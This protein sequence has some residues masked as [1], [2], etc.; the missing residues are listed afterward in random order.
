MET[1]LQDDDLL[2]AGIDEAGYGPLLGPLC[3]AMTVVRVRDVPECPPDLWDLLDRAVCREGKDA[4]TSR[5]AVNDSKRLKLANSSEKR[6]P[7]MH[8][9]RG[10]LAFGAQCGGRE[11][12]STDE[13][14]LEMLGVG[15][16]CPWYTGAPRALPLSTTAEHLGLLRSG[17]T[18]ALRQAGVEMLDMHCRAV[19][20]QGFN[21]RLADVGVKSRVCSG[22]VGELMRRVWGSQACARCTDRP[23]R[24]V[25]DR[26]GGRRSYV[27]L[28]ETE[29][30]DGRVQV[31]R[32]RP[33]GS[34]YDV[35][36]AD[37]R[38]LRV[39]FLTEA[40]RQH[41]PVA[42]A[43]MTA[44]LVRELAMARFNRYWSSRASELKPTAG[45][46]TDARRWLADAERLGAADASSLEGLCRN[47]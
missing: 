9:E 30:P 16:A 2:Y 35:T 33:E 15:L 47:A 34:V 6:H 13:E 27:G 21:S 41:F 3:V 7:L 23:A 18:A 46:R 10:V 31:V 14:L 39:L 20:E 43:S 28:L 45:Y 42:L 24:I 40:E 1:A 22:M 5:L 37:G 11:L 25:V 32:E 19:D 17:L 29:L 8:L 44:K 12:A 36:H 38:S 26:Q 4:G